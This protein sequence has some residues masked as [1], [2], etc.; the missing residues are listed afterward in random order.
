MADGSADTQ[1]SVGPTA[2]EGKVVGGRKAEMPQLAAGVA[3]CPPLSITS[4]NPDELAE[5]PC[6]C[7]LSAE[8]K[9][10]VAREPTLASQAQLGQIK[11]A[12][13]SPA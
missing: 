7:D 2:R 10:Q 12:C 1:A 4:A 5:R 8:S 6:P 11:T 3:P 9:R 13:P